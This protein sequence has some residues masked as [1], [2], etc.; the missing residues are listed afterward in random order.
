MVCLSLRHISVL[1]HACLV[2]HSSLTAV[3]TKTLESLQQRAMKIIF[4]DKDYTFSLI[5]ANIDTLET[6]LEQLTG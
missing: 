6:W 2:W 4:L 3:Q 5:F 1:E